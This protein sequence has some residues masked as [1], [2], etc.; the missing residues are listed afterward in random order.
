MFS[1]AMF[2]LCALDLALLA[3]TFLRWR[4]LR[5]PVLGLI[6]FLLLA[7]PYDTALV[8]A[9][10]W[11]GEGAFLER[12]SGPRFMLFS[13]SLPLTMVL[14]AG[15]ARLAGIGWL[16]PRWVMGAVCL[17]ASGFIVLDWRSILLFPQLYPACWQDTL[18]YV[19]SV[20]AEQACSAAQAGVGLPGRFPPAAALAVP[21]LFVSAAL[22]WWRARWPWMLAGTLAGFAFLGLPPRLVGPIPGFLGDSL[23]MLALAVT[24]ARLA[25]RGSRAVAAASG[26]PRLAK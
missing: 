3:W 7:L 11:I 9:G 26:Q 22:V 20:L 19:P 25:P 23:S 13:L 6:V 4:E 17:A 18:R 1:A 5:H 16:Q 21:M 12:L 8:G 15:M 2:V 10:R 24:A 14:A